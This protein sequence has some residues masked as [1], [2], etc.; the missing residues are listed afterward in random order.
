MGRY[1]IYFTSRLYR[2]TS[3]PY[4]YCFMLFRKSYLFHEPPESI[5]RLVYEIK[6]AASAARG[7]LKQYQ[8][9]SGNQ[10][11]GCFVNVHCVTNVTENSTTH[12]V[13]KELFQCVC[14]PKALHSCE[15]M[16]ALLRV[17]YEGEC[18]FIHTGF[19]ISVQRS[20]ILNEILASRNK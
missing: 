20:A 8:T 19:V 18:S 4:L 11:T 16:T 2:P 15:H 6:R 7:N 14:H 12:G 5:S 9:S 3:V 13:L 1:F 10:R 17:H